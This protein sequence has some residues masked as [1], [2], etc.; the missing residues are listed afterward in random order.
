M[1]HAEDDVPLPFKLMLLSILAN[2]QSMAL[3]ELLQY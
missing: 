1:Q 2:A 3:L